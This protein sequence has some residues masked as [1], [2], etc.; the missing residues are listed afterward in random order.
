MTKL[1][2]WMD[3]HVDESGK[4]HPVTDMDDALHPLV[5]AMLL[6]LAACVVIAVITW[7]ALPAG[8][9]EQAPAAGTTTT[10]QP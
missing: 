5:G 1:T 7:L 3:R 9:S 8:R 4:E 2:R 10:V 6:V